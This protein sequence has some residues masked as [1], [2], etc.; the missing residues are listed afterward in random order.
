MW[1]LVWSRT[2]WN[3]KNK[4]SHK[5]QGKREKGVLSIRSWNRRKRA[6][7]KMVE[8]EDSEYTSGYYDDAGEKQNYLEEW[9][10]ERS[11][12]KEDTEVQ[13]VPRNIKDNVEGRRKKRK[14]KILA[15]AL[16]ARAQSSACLSPCANVCTTTRVFVRRN[17]TQIF[18]T[19]RRTSED[20]TKQLLNL[21]DLCLT[22][23][24]RLDRLNRR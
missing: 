15:A 11:S 22:W 7:C 23:Y 1:S 5:T 19:T 20:E 4:K 6:E 10:R 12:V 13:N 3:K 2:R 18:P 14:R 21:D 24:G 9:E 8:R 17:G 16:F